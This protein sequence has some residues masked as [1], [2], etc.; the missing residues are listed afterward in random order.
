M[1]NVWIMNGVQ[2][3]ADVPVK[4]TPSVFAYSMIYPYS[5]NFLDD[6][7]VTEEEKQA[8]SKRF[9]QRLHGYGIK[10]IIR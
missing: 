1:R 9:N 5:D 8:F 2:L 4:I 7:N 6:P 3:M 10:S